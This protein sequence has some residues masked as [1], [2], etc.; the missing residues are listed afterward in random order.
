[1]HDFSRFSRLSSG[2]KTLLFTAVAV[3]VTDGILL[4]YY[5][6]YWRLP[7]TQGVKIHR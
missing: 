2:T 7:H 3:K 1:M 5:Y 4:F 6:V